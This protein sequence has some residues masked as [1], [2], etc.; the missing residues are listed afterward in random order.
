MKKNRNGTK[1]ILY[2][3]QFL[4]MLLI[5]IIT[6]YFPAIVYVSVLKTYNDY[7]LNREK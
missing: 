4:H 5:I 1:Y 3:R 7:H 2:L 6:P